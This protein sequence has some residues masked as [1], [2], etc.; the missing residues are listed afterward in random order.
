MLNTLGV[1]VDHKLLWKTHL[2]RKREEL[3][4]RFRSMYCLL[5][6]KN[7]VIEPKKDCSTLRSFARSVSKN[8]R[9]QYQHHP[10]MSEHFT[11]NDDSTMVNSQRWAS[12]KITEPWTHTSSASTVTQI[13]RLSN[14]CMD[15]RSIALNENV[16]KTYYYELVEPITH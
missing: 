15:Y 10:K 9:Q 3:N 7:H 11:E 8:S 14:F 6:V 13:S 1:H 4:L 5:R 2:Q 16:S 12:C